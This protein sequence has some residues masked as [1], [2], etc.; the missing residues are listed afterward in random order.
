[1]QKNTDEIIVGLR[2]ILTDDNFRE[3]ISK[4]S[5]KTYYEKINIDKTINKNIN[6]IKRL[7]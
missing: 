3:Y 2:S 6:L 5:Y 1:M 7:I 4:N